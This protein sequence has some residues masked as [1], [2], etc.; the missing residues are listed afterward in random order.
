MGSTSK[1]K[2][3][4]KNSQPP[5][6]KVSENLATNIYQGLNPQPDA[7]CSYSDT[8]GKQQEDGASDNELEIPE[9]CIDGASEDE[10]LQ[11]ANAL[12]TEQVVKRRAR[13][14]KQLAR[15]YRRHYWAL[16]ED[17]KSKYREFYMKNGRSVLKVEV[18]EED[19]EERDFVD[20][21]GEATGSIR[22]RKENGVAIV[23][24]CFQGCKSKPMA[25][26]SFCHNH[27]LSDARQQLYKPCSYVIKR[28][29]KPVTC[30]KPVLKAA[31]PSLCTVHF[32][33]AQK[34]VAYSLQRAGL[35]T[36]SK[37]AP[38]FHHIIS[39]Y[40]NYIQSKRKDAWIAGP[41]HN[42]DT[43]DSTI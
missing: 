36:S 32:Q 39:E 1:Q 9:I 7:S 19:E 25:L 11:N 6:R 8:D 27:I 29:N 3:A 24:C 17:L 23:K 37:S 5:T 22:M 20:R 18:E 30:G 10:L 16:M 31:V 34:H 12:T 26:C 2:L 43:K 40:V 41:V 33:K 28:Q 42:A 35:N 4:K 14:M 15:L 38:K 13:R 21:S